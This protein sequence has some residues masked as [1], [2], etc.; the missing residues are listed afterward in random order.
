MTDQRLRERLRNWG[1][2][3]NHETRSGPDRARCTS[4][5]SHH[6]PPADDVYEARDVYPVPNVADAERIEAALRKLT[7][8][9]LIGVMERYC[10]AVRYGGYAAV[11]RARRVGEHAME[12]LAD[13]CEAALA[14]QLFNR[15]RRG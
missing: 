11:F 3:L 2:W 14:A 12:K 10:L 7:Q 15:M 13:N 8:D 1:Y 9:G 6:V 5:E 4:A